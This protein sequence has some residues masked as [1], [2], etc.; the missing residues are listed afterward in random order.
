MNKV[1]LGRGLGIW[2]LSYTQPTPHPP[3]IG[4]SNAGHLSWGLETIALD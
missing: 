2:I 4:D 3:T 1:P